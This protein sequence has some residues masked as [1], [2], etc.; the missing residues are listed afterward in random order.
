MSFWRQ[1]RQPGAQGPADTG[2]RRALTDDTFD[3]LTRAAGGCATRR[4]VLKLLFTTVGVALVAPESFGNRATSPKSGASPLMSSLASSGPTSACPPLEGERCCT[5]PELLTCD[6]TAGSEF[7][8]AL[9]LCSRQCSHQQV[10]SPSCQQCISTATLQSSAIYTNCMSATCLTLPSPPATLSAPQTQ[11]ASASTEAP[12]PAASLL[13]YQ[14]PLTVSCDWGKFSGCMADSTSKLELCLAQCAMNIFAGKQPICAPICYGLYSFRNLSCAKKADTC[15]PPTF[16]TPESI[17]CDVSQTPCNDQCVDTQTDPS[18]CGSCGNVCPAGEQCV[19]GACGCGGVSC[20]PPNTCCNNQC[21]NTQTDPNNCGSCG[22]ACPP[23]N[24]C[25][26]GAC[27]GC[28][29]TSKCGPG[30]FCCTA[31]GASTCCVTGQGCVYCN[32]SANCVPSG[33]NLQCCDTVLYDPST[34]KCCPGTNYHVCTLDAYCCPAD[35]S[36]NPCP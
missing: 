13:A 34:A 35:C 10:S 36:V 32:G 21:V 5:P 20:G 28:G 15:P 14:Q 11:A 18:N 17:C 24:T 22:N 7:V 8:K 9:K 19:Q 33:S 31:G 25:D 16:C 12:P 1:P 3:D 23:G 29:G 2:R 6:R 4:G 26:A 30:E 27:S